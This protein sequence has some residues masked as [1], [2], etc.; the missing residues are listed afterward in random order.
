M[1]AVEASEAQGMT[2]T[3]AGLLATERD[4]DEAFGLKLLVPGEDSF[5]E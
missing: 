5:V 3:T 4:D 2:S 1:S